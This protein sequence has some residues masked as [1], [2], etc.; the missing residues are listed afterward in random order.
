M[1]LS[2]A[3]G[4][5]LALV[6][7]APG[8]AAPD[9]TLSAS[10]ARATFLRAQSPNTTLYSGTLKLTVTNAGADPTDGS[11]VTVTETLPAGLSALVNNP[12]LGAGPTAA[13]GPGWTCTGTS[14]SRCTRSAVLAPGASYPPITMTVSVA[15]GAAATLVNAP[16]VVGRGGTTP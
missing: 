3:V 5:A 14:T 11:P 6:T 2:L 9:L 13:S 10:H 4:A 1:K 7:A 15:A 12:G 16:N 8:Q